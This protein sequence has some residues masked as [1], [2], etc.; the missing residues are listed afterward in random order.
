MVSKLARRVQQDHS[1]RLWTRPHPQRHLPYAAQVSHTTSPYFYHQCV[2]L[3]SIQSPAPKLI[4]FYWKGIFWVW[5]VST[6]K[7]LAPPLIP[8]QREPWQDSPPLFKYVKKCADSGSVIEESG[9]TRLLLP[10]AVGPCDG[11]GHTVDSGL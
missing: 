1:I 2:Q 6:S 4:A 10:F 5:S 3:S 7:V 8:H 9:K 11:C